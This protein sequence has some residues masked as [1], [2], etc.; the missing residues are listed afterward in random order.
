MTKHNLLVSEGLLKGRYCDFPRILC[1][2]W[3]PL[4][5]YWLIY[6]HL[7][8]TLMSL[9][10][11]RGHEL[12][13]W[14]QFSFS[15]PGCLTLLYSVI[16]QDS[17]IQACLSWCR[18]WWLLLSHLLNNRCAGGQTHKETMP[19]QPPPHCSKNAYIWL[20]CLRIIC[21]FANKSH[22]IVIHN[23]TWTMVRT[24]RIWIFYFFKWIL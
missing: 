8:V 23:L 6:S 17:T 4:D 15:T 5:S 7:H 19:T 9:S 3:K 18:V 16:W 22:I 11:D 2:N 10:E 13:I 1:F 14:C 24:H 20:M 21:R 12:Q